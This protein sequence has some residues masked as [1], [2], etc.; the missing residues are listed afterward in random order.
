MTKKKFV[1]LKLTL[2][3]MEITY[4]HKTNYSCMNK[5]N[6][7]FSF[8]APH[9]SLCYITAILATKNINFFWWFLTNAENK[10]HYGSYPV[11]LPVHI[12]KLWSTVSGH[13]HKLHSHSQFHFVYLIKLYFCPYNVILIRKITIQT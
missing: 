12:H 9:W 1:V 6:S 4:R 2:W 10:R 11:F 3:H 8:C 7:L 13:Q 5:T